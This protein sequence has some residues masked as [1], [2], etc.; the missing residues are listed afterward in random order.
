VVSHFRCRSTFDLLLCWK[1]II[2]ISLA[3]AAGVPPA[4]SLIRN[5]SV[6]P[7]F[8]DRHFFW[9]VSGVPYFEPEL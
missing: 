4:V 6:P 2:W 7:L 9:F 3:V 1:G 5:S 8:S